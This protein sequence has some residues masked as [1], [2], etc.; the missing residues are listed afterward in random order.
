MISEFSL[1]EKKKYGSPNASTFGPATCEN[2]LEFDVIQTPTGP[3]VVGHDA[4]SEILG[5]SKRPWFASASGEMLVPLGPP[6]NSALAALT[7]FCWW[8]SADSP[9]GDIGGQILFRQPIR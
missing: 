3:A 9:T 5:V 6:I 1:L 4:A 7:V 8:S 2:G